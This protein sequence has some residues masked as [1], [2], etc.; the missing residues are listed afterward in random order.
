[1]IT[2]VNFNEKGILEL[3]MSPVQIAAR[4]GFLHIVEEHGNGKWA[5]EELEYK[6]YVEHIDEYE[7]LNEEEKYDLNTFMISFRSLYK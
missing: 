4:E 7:A 3:Y 1:M 2:P 6:V 5:F